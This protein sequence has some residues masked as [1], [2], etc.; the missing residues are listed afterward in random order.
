M[1]ADRP[2]SPASMMVDRPSLSLPLANSL[3]SHALAIFDGVTLA[4]PGS[5]GQSASGI[6]CL[7][8]EGIE[9][10]GRCKCLVRTCSN[11]A[12]SGFGSQALRVARRA[13]RPG[14][15]QLPTYRR[16]PEMVT[17][18]VSSRK[19]SGYWPCLHTPH[20]YLR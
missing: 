8:P 18:L 4:A 3:H 13:C 19:R 12:R 5:A 7:E 10:Y 1:W 16:P 2:P 14:A 9:P 11:G 6:I 17:T 20:C 15:A